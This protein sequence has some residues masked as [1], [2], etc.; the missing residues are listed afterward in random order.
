LG[1]ILNPWEEDVVLAVGQSLLLHEAS[2][3]L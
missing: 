1:K 2:D 3:E